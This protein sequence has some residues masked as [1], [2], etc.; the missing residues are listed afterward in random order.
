M[1]LTD[2]FVCY[3]EEMPSCSYLPEDI[4][5]NIL[6]RLPAKSIGRFRCVS[7]PWQVLLSTPQFIKTH[8]DRI[9]KLRQESLFLVSYSRNFTSLTLNNA[10]Q[11]F[12]EIT[13]S[14]KKLSFAGHPDSWTEVFGSC[15]GLILVGDD[16]D[17]KFMINPTTREI[18]QVPTSPFALDPRV[19]YTIYGFGYDSVNDDYKVVALSHYY[20]TDN[21]LVPDYTEMFVHV[22]SVT[23]GTWKRCGS[24]LYDLDL[25]VDHIIS[26]VFVD[27]CIHWLARR[28][29]DYS[30]VVAAF[31]LEEEKFC[32]V[33]PH[34]SIDHDKILS[35]Y[36]EVLGGCLCMCS[37]H[38]DVWVMKEYGIEQS[39]A[40]FTII[41]PHGS[42]F[43]PLCLLGK[44]H[45]V[46]MKYEGFTT[47]EKLV[48]YNLEE[49][50]FNDVAIHGITDG[51]FSVWGTFMETLISPHRSNEMG[52]GH[53]N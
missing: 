31:D 4:I 40:K 3:D 35:D 48:A 51:N 49:K 30:V 15:N 11:L 41:D 25:V 2:S 46:L 34:S 7:K 6:S 39:W 28:V 43:R 26:G 13:A 23:N 33:P 37:N 42:G 20:D 24:S 19:S 38:I 9:T 53:V 52:R 5:V 1:R 44:E 50:T 16:Q 12:D 45:M 10:H 29:T 32:E 21:E 8:L 17:K 47:H 18:R 36:L 27:R 14:A 22:Y